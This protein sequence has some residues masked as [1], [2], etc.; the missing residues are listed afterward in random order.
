MFTELLEIGVQEHSK[1]VP[2]FGSIGE[3]DGIGFKLFLYGLNEL[4]RGE[5]VDLPGDS[6]VVLIIEGDDVVRELFNRAFVHGHVTFADQ[7][8]VSNV[9]YVLP[10]S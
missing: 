7:G 8:S 5:I 9:K 10:I 3:R 4:I 2:K 1:Q 6:Q